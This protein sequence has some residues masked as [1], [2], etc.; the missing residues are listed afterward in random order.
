MEKLQ[1]T[2]WEKLLREVGKAVKIKL[3]ENP[4]SL[5]LIKS[6]IAL[7]RLA[8]FVIMYSNTLSRPEYPVFTNLDFSELTIFKVFT[9]ILII[10]CH[11]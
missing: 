1:S 9:K 11:E 10:K 4:K 5:S 3:C 2:G 8:P 6:E 7:L